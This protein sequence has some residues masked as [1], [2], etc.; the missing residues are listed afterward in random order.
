MKTTIY[1][2]LLIAV[3]PVA[4][5]ALFTA[6]VINRVNLASQDEPMQVVGYSSQDECETQSGEACEM[7][8]TESSDQFWVV[9][10]Q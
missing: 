10:K 3:V 7:V 4:Y 8:T 9:A 5:I 1:A 2:V 6:G